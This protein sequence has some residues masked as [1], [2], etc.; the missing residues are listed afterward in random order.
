M[1]VDGTVG[2]DVELQ[3]MVENQVKVALASVDLQMP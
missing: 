3:P 1:V 2:T